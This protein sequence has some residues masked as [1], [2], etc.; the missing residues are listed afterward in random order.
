MQH[1]LS[2]VPVIVLACAGVLAPARA[3]EARAG[4]AAAPLAAVHEHVVE[5]PVP[6]VTA[7]DGCVTVH[8]VW[9]PQVLALHRTAARSDA[10]V[11]AFEENVRQPYEELW[12]SYVGTSDV[13]ARWVRNR[14]QV[15]HDARRTLPVELN[16][17]ELIAATTSGMM[18][19]TGRRG[20]GEWYALFGPGQTD[21]GS[22]GNGRIVIDFLGLPV[23]TSADS[24]LLTVAHEVNHLMFAARREHDPHAG[25]VLYRMIDEGLAAYVAHHYS[26]PI[27]SPARA[28]SW[29]EEELAWA[30]RHER[31]LW[32]MLQRYVYA[33]HPDVFDA[34]FMYDQ[35]VRPG[36]PGKIGYF[37]GYRIIEAYVRRH[38]PE[39]WRDLYDMNVMEI[40][41]QSRIIVRPWAV[42]A[43]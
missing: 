16:M 27:G 37:L 3:Q 10:R 5:D 29:T 12:R 30:M 20:C 21:M 28:L 22:L 6:S 24:I 35:Q 7:L 13:F 9:K 8:D 4:G 40:L 19:F 18:A 15:E 39:S 32:T 38:G 11:A 31:E 1:S 33:T 25:T 43:R 17:A 41:D 34:F 42:G 26:G 14:L 23:K 36:A 2:F